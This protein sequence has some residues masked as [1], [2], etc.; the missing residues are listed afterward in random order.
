M[1]ARDRRVWRRRTAALALVV[2]IGATVYGDNR[3]LSGSRLAAPVA[4]A[5]QAGHMVGLWARS[6]GNAASI[7]VLYATVLSR[8]DPASR[9]SILAAIEDV[10]DFC[11]A[12]RPPPA[13][14]RCAAKSRGGKPVRCSRA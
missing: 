14:S 8:L 9:R 5:V 2:V 1:E 4:G 3:S 11:T 12:R 6:V 13:A 10:R 7:G